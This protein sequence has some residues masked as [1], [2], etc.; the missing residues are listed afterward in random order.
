VNNYLSRVALLSQTGI[1]S[2]FPDFSVES[3]EFHWSFVCETVSN[4]Q[5]CVRVHDAHFFHNLLEHGHEFSNF[6]RSECRKHDSSVAFVSI[7][8]NLISHE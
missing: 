1:S 5:R 8:C 3:A 7:T 4:V 2:T 6:V